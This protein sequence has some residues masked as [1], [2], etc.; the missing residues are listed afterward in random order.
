MQKVTTFLWFDGN[1]ADAAHFYVSVFKDSEIVNVMPG[2]G[3]QPMGATISLFG[4]HF[5]LFNGGPMFKLSE[6]VSLFVNA[7]TQE[8]IDYLWEKL[9]EGGEKSRCGWLKDRFGLSWQIVPPELGKFLSDKDAKKAGNVM[10]AMLQ[11]NKLDI[12]KLKAAYD[13]E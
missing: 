10:Q 11:M 1:A 9:S 5:I 4:Q 13:K 12:A 8:E 6:A 2:P 7:E 3:G